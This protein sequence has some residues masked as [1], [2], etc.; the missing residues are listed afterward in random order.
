VQAGPGVRCQLKEIRQQ[1]RR[2]VRLADHGLIADLGGLARIQS[3]HPVQGCLGEPAPA[4]RGANDVG[5]Q[6]EL[7]APLRLHPPPGGRP[8]Q[9]PAASAP[10]R[11]RRGGRQPWL[12]GV[13]YGSI[14]PVP[15]NVHELG[16]GE[17]LRQERHQEAVLRVLLGEPAPAV[18]RGQ[19]Q[20]P[21]GQ[22][23]DRAAATLAPRSFIHG[24]GSCLGQPRLEVVGDPGQPSQAVAKERRARPGRADNEDGP[25]RPGVECVRG[26]LVPQRTVPAPVAH[27]GGDRDGA[28]LQGASPGQVR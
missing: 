8:V 14:P 11:R 27:V 13:R 23:E 26:H 25:V 5:D 3:G 24:A 6:R 16:A 9:L 21:V 18:Q 15:D 7:R 12:L 22:P 20:R 19:Q 17:L 10:A 1:V 28:E 4:P 2:A